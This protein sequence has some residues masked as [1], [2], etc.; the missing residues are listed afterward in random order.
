[1]NNPKITPG[2]SNEAEKQ[3]ISSESTPKRSFQIRRPKD[4]HE[5]TREQIEKDIINQMTDQGIDPKDIDYEFVKRITDDITG[6]VK[7]KEIGQSVIKKIR[8][9]TLISMLAV[10]AT[11]SILVFQVADR[12][13]EKEQIQNDIEFSIKNGATLD[14]LKIIYR[15]NAQPVDSLW[16]VVKKNRYYD[17]NNLTLQRVLEDIKTK[18]LINPNGIKDEENELRKLIDTALSEYV[19]VNPFD[20]LDD[21]DKKMLSNIGIKLSSDIYDRIKPEVEGLTS[22]LKIKNSLIKEY[23]SSSN[24]SLYISLAAFVFAILVTFWQ[25]LPKTK[26]SQK[27]LISE[28]IKDHINNLNIDSNE[29]KIK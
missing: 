4:F 28:A 15:N 27:Q 10:L 5:K 17:L 12:F 2:N 23:L 16:P 6:R 14:E 22:S 9:M 29:R 18:K 3:K 11:A 24:M 21:N 19:R 8:F 25:F 1:M 13:V 26:A 20:G 7:R